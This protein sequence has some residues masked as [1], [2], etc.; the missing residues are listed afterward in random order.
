MPTDTPDL[1]AIRERYICEPFDQG[2]WRVYG[3]G[4]SGT[5][6]DKDYAEN[7]AQMMN[8]AAFSAASEALA[9]IDRLTAERDAQAARIEVL[10][11]ALDQIATQRFSPCETNEATI[12]RAALTPP[13]E[14][15]P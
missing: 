4:Y 6:T 14:P 10:E 2:L 8:H 3:P 11:K 15:R 1:S 12:A 9:H 7:Q 5:F 13:P